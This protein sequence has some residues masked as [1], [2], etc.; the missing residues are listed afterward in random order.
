VTVPGAS[1]CDGVS[2]VNV[3]GGPGASPADLVERG[4]CHLTGG[5]RHLTGSPYRAAPRRSVRIDE[6]LEGIDWGA[7]QS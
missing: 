4:Q 3:T 7:G 5:A 1:P 6:S 2:Q